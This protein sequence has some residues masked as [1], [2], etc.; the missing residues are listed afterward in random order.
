MAVAEFAQAPEDAADLQ[1]WSFAHASHHV[2]IIRVVSEQFGKRL[3]NWILDPFDPNDVTA[4]IYFHQVM[5]NQF[6]Q[7]LNL[8]GQ[9]L[10]DL[11]W[12]NI[13]NVTDWVYTNSNEHQQAAA[14]LGIG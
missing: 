11:D 6:N 4:W 2:D 9:D 8:Q 10:T 3:D 12:S 13:D 1:R 7:V 14:I 5:H